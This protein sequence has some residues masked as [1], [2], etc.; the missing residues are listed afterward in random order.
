LR[1]IARLSYTPNQ[2]GA[3]ERQ[4]QTRE[5]KRMSQ[6][7]AE[8]P[9]DLRDIIEN[10]VTE[11]DEQQEAIKIRSSPFIRLLPSFNYPCSLRQPDSPQQVGQARIIA[12]S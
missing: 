11:D 3:S 5:V 12:E 6:A 2:A 1:I 8:I 10:I 7:L 4:N 9:Y